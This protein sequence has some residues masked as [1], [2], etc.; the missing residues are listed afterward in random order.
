MFLKQ[1]KEIDEFCVRIRDKKNIGKE[2]DKFI[3]KNYD[4]QEIRR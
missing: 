2:N 4:K 1:Y 3:V